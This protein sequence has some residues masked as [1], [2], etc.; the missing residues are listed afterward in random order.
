MLAMRASGVDHQQRHH[1]PFQAAQQHLLAIHELDDKLGRFP[2][3]RGDFRFR[4]FRFGGRRI[5]SDPS[6]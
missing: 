6:E 5:Q 1:F 2:K 3:H 4:G